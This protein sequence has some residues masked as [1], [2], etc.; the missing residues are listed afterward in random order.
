MVLY[1]LERAAQP[2][3]ASLVGY[4]DDAREAALFLTPEAAEKNKRSTY[5]AEFHVVEIHIEGKNDGND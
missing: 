2:R 3:Y 5:A 1:A 4:R